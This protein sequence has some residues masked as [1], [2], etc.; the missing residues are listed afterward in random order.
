MEGVIPPRLITDLAERGGQTE[1]ADSFRHLLSRCHLN[2]RFRRYVGMNS[3]TWLAD[4]AL[5][6]HDPACAGA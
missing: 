3:G 1:V 6:G 4:N 2:G 5:L